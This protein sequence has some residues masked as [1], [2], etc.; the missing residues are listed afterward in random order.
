MRVSDSFSPD[1][2]NA[3]NN[4]SGRVRFIALHIMNVRINPEAPTREPATIN[5]ELLMMNP[6]KAAILDSE[7]SKENDY[8]HISTTDWQYQQDAKNR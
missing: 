4:T 8:W 5:T 1:P 3:L 2:P 7:L 6:V